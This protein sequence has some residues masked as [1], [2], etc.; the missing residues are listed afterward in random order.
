VKCSQVFLFKERRIVSGY[1]RD[2]PIPI[3]RGPWEANELWPSLYSLSFHGL[4]RIGVRYSL[5][6][7]GNCLDRS[8]IRK[9]IGL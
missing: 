9:G 2:A 4:E 8:P 3:R 1:V 7:G 5:V 6:T